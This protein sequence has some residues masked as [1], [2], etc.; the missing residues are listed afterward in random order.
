M[1]TALESENGTTK[2]KNSYLKMLTCSMGI[3][4]L[5]L[6]TSFLINSFFPVAKICVTLLCY[7]GYI[8]WG[9]TLGA[10][11]SKI[12]TWG[13]KSHE[14]LLDQKLSTILSLIGIFAFAM[15]QGLEP[16]T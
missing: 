6:V 14:E 16:L 13:Q 15:A 10:L 7:T 1:S 4:L 2:V 11:G 3:V 12:L 5:A 8:C 9:T